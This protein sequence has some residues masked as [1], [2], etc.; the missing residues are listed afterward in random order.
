MSKSPETHIVKKKMEYS[1]RLL[2]QPEGAH[3]QGRGNRGR[4]SGGVGLVS[5][6]GRGERKRQRFSSNEYLVG[7]LPES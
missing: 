2:L 7:V 6:G 5:G 4:V 3:S 1:S